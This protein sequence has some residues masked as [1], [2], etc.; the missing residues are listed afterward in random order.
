[1]NTLKVLVNNS[2]K[3]N[4]YG[5][6]KKINIL[7]TI[8]ISYKNSVKIFLKLKLNLE[9]SQKLINLKRLFKS[10]KY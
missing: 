7:T 6:R 5:K 8:F 2:F 9:L 4:F 10:P 1:M 3:E